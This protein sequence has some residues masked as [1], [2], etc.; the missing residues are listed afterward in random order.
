MSDVYLYFEIRP[1]AGGAGEREHDGG[2]VSPSFKWWTTDAEVLFHISV[3]GNFIVYLQDRSETNLFL[4]ITAIRAPRSFRRV[5]QN[6]S[7]CF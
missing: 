3:I 5:F 6:F 2:I 1:S 4:I 7:Y